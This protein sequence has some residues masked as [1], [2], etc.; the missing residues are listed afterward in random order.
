[1]DVRKEPADSGQPKTLYDEKQLAAR[2]LN[3]TNIRETK[4][5]GL[6]DLSG[7]EPTA[8]DQTYR[9]R[10]LIGVSLLVSGIGI[11]NALLMSVTE[12]FQEIGTLKCLG[13]RDK[14]VVELF[15]IESG[16]LGLIGSVFGAVAG[17]VIA[18]GSNAVTYGWQPVWTNLPWRSL[19]LFGLLSVIVG[20]VVAMAAAIYP[21]FV[22]ARMT[23]AD[24]LRSE[25]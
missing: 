20:L 12:R 1:M 2:G 3:Y 18:I 8:A 15:I 17:L 19:L 4:T 5:A 11:A 7:S 10:W 9:T 25:V 16:V 14:L 21:A 6:A 23:P 24:A 13:S 22:A